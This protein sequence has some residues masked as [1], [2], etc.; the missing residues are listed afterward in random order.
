MIGALEVDVALEVVASCAD[1]F[2]INVSVEV[3]AVA[4]FVT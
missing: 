1:S 3:E 2:V 4:T